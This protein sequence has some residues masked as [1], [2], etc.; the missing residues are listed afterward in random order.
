MTVAPCSAASASWLDFQDIV[1]QEKGLVP[2]DSVN[3]KQ[4]YKPSKSK[5]QVFL[6]HY[7]VKQKNAAQAKKHW[8]E[9]VQFIEKYDK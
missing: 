7:Q 3:P 2:E 6:R 4:I 9:I 1:S 5:K 8:T